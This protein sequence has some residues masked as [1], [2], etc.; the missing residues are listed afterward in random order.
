MKQTKGNPFLNVTGFETDYSAFYFALVRD[1]VFYCVSAVALEN[2]IFE[3]WHSI[4]KVY[5]AVLTLEDANLFSTNMYSW[6]KELDGE[7]LFCNT[8]TAKK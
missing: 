2:D 4:N 6:V 7:F 5:R 8:A 3:C 1:A